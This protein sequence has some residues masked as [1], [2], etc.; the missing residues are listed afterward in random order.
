M[1]TPNQTFTVVPDTGS[2]NLWIY[3]SK[4]AAIVCK[5]HSTYDASKSSTYEADGTAFDISYGSGSITGSVSRDIATLGDV[6]A[7]NFGFGEVSS[8]KG[9]SFY[10]SQMS[11]ILGLAYASI[12][13]DNLPVFIDEA[14]IWDKSFSFVLKETDE[15]SYMT[16]PGYDET[17]IVGEFMWHN[18][19]EQ[20]YWALNLTTIMSGK[21]GIDATKYKAVIDSGTSVLVGPTKLVK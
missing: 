14:N 17:S 21:T 15:D 13:V 8:A 5:L 18:V 6:S 20:K 2:S 1:G 16:I 12:S 4:C 11:G 19:T 3:S 10:A 7:E 9:A